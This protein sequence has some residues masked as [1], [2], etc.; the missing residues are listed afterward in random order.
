M[1]TAW[2]ISIINIGLYFLIF[3]LSFSAYKKNRKNK[4]AIILLVATLIVF[5]MN[6]II[7]LKT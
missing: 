3:L 7:I 5:V 2:T 4:M 6:L 1:N